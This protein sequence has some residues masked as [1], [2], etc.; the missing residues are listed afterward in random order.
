M[1]QF[2]AKQYGVDAKLALAVAKVESDLAPDVVSSAGAVG[3][4]QLMPETAFRNKALVI[5]KIPD[6]ILMVAY[7]I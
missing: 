3:V 5:V 7:G 2:T 4:M 1:I 6:K